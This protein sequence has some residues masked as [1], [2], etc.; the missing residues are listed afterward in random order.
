ME[1]PSTVPSAEPFRIR[2]HSVAETEAWAARLAASVPAGTV[3]ALHGELGAGKTAF[4][5]GF[6]RG[7]GHAGRVHSPTFSL[8]NEYIGGRCPVHHLDLYRLNAAADVGAAGLEEYLM[9]P[10]GITLVEWAERWTEGAAPP[11]H[12]RQVRLDVVDE[13]EGED[14]RAIECDWHP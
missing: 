1:L 2:T 7:L 11:S 3:V 8:L 10:A 5:R 14:V 6:A 13:G 9:H 12:W 4:A